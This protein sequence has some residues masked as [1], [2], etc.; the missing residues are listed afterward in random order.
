M[1]FIELRLGDNDKK[2]VWGGSTLPHPPASSVTQLQTALR[3][4]EGRFNLQ[5]HH[6]KLP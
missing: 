3:A 6:V 1:A 5:V 4:V 2:S